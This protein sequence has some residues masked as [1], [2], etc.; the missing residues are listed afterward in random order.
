MRAQQLARDPAKMIPTTSKTQ[1]YVYLFHPIRAQ[2]VTVGRLDVYT[3]NGTGAFVY[4]PSFLDDKDALS[5]DPVNLP[6]TEQRHT[7]GAPRYQGLHDVFRDSGPDAW[8]Q[9]VLHREQALSPGAHAVRYLIQSGNSARWGALAFGRTRK[10]NIALFATPRLERLE[11]L[12]SELLAIF[13]SRPPK[14]EA[15]RRLLVQTPSLGGARPKATVR[16]RDGVHW[17][18]KP[19]H[20]GDIHD[21]PQVEHAVAQWGSAAGL[22][23]SPTQVYYGEQERMQGISMLASCRFDRQ[24]LRRHMVLSAATLLGAHFPVVSSRDVEKWSYPRL[25]L[26]LRQIGAPLADR[27]ELFGRMIFNALIGND[28]DHPRNHAVFFDPIDQL[29]RLAPA[30]DVVPNL[31]MDPPRLAMQLSQGRFECSK[32]AI[33][34]DALKFGFESEQQARAALVDN[35]VA[36]SETVEVA[37]EKISAGAVRDLL[38]QR[39]RDRANILMP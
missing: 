36:F 2:W 29:W 1:C 26:A 35:L 16:D 17:L 37:L 8:G 3:G 38:Y 7:Y 19:R 15:L 34:A 30:Y 33:L 28:D 18:V 21:I 10:P 39:V 6:L 9:L 32:Q 24:G 22:N 13:E 25:A 20:S 14:N 31:E 23:F 4:A 27:Y 11:A 5:I 12:C